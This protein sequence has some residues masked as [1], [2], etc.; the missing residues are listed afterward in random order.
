LGLIIRTDPGALRL[1]PSRQ[2]GADP[3]KLAAQ[4]GQY[5]GSLRGMLPVQ[6][7]RG[8]DGELMINDG[9]TRA[10]RIAKLQPEATIEVEVIDDRPR[11]S[12]EHLVRVRERL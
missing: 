12:F 2:S 6:V 5:G 8:K 1:P 7:T 9:V 10:T 3:V 4:I 11:I